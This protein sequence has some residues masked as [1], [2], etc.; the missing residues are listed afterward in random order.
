MRITLIIHA[1]NGGGAERV[2]T[3][4]AAYWAQAGKSVHVICMDDG[5]NPPFYPQH[6]S[7]GR[8][9]LGLLRN[10][11][12]LWQ[13]A[14]R[15]PPRLLAIRRAI[16]RSKPSIIVSFIDKMNI[17]TLLSTAGL[18]IPI[19]ACEH[20]YPKGRSIGKAWEFLRLVT[21]PRA[22][23]VVT[24]TESGLRCFSGSIQ[25]RGAVIPN[26]VTVPPGYRGCA[27]TKAARTDKTLIALG[28]ISRVKGFDLLVT[29]FAAVSQQHPNWSLEIWGEGRSRRDIEASVRALNIGHRV[30]LPGVTRE[31]LEKLKT[32]DLFVLSSRTEG[33][34]MALCEA[35]ACGLPVVSFDC[36]SGPREVVREGVDGILV[37]PG[38]VAALAEALGRLMGDDALRK[39]LGN[40]GPEVLDRFSIESVMQK[41]ERLIAKVTQ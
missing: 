33:F 13:S 23:A 6:P 36:L 17:L 25:N 8:E 2:M 40:R 1:I 39:S 30:R 16:R 26:P 27:L 41:W 28:R 37:S 32:A 12:N 38:N 4:L 5:K 19:L 22:A 3:N 10:S 7:V 20:T 18:G 9:H 15:T 24:L 29:A 34:P 11:N 21:Y 14:V 35:M 31:P